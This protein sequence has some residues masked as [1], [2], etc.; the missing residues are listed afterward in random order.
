MNQDHLDKAID[1]VAAQ[2]TRV[3][4]DPQLAARIASSLPERTTWFGWLF[5]A[6]APRLAMLAVV[7]TGAALVLN[8]NAQPPVTDAPEP[9]LIAKSEPKLPRLPEPAPPVE[10]VEPGNPVGTKPVE[11]VEPLEPLEPAER[12][13]HERSLAALDVEAL[14]PMALPEEASIEVV[15]LAISDLPLSGETVIQRD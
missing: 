11:P 15:P 14:M 13:D 3:D 2:L 8:R 6:W 9:V 10:P 5:H 7:V 4:D 1:H 12:R